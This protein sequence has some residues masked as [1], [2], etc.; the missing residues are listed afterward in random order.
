MFP[1]PSAPFTQVWRRIVVEW[2]VKDLLH[3]KAALGPTRILQPFCNVQKERGEITFPLSFC[4]PYVCKG[5]LPHWNSPFL[6]RSLSPLHP[7][8]SVQ[9]QRRDIKTCPLSFCTLMNVEKDLFLYRLALAP[10]PGPSA[11]CRRKEE[12]LTCLLILSVPSS[13]CGKRLGILSAKPVTS[14]TPGN[15]STDPRLGTIELPHKAKFDFASYSL[16][17]LDWCYLCFFSTAIRQSI[18]KALVAY[19]QKCELFNVTFFSYLLVRYII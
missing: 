14:Q 12:T 13:K 7:F 9:K 8:S 18:S 6:H 2:E 16:F 4:I 5:T 1:F 11:V 17:H 19:Y 15:K 3:N 10:T